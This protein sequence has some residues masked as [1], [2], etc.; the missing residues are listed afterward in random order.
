[1]PQWFVV[2]V[3]DTAVLAAASARNRTLIL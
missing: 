1:L 2:D 3:A